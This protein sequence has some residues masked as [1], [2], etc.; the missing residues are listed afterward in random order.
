MFG[1]FLFTT[2][3]QKPKHDI[4]IDKYIDFLKHNNNQAKEY[5]LDLIENNDLVIL[6]E[7]DHRENT[8]YKFLKELMSDPRFIKNVGNI[9][10]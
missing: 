2:C 1:F 7:R 9:F 8:Q 4:K 10:K 3:N 6:C 5:I